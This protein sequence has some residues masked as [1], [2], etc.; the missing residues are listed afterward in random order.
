MLVSVLILWLGCLTTFLASPQ[1]KFLAKRLNKKLA[2]SVFATFYVVASVIASNTYPAVSAWI[3]TFAIVS[4]MWVGTV[5]SLGH[6]QPSLWSFACGGGALSLL[7]IG[8][9]G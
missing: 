2:W 6:I 9:G 1:Q 8:I 7:V 3:L 4:L 5:F